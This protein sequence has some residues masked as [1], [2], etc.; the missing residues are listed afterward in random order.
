[1]IDKK[2]FAPPWMRANANMNEKEPVFATGCIFA[3]DLYSFPHTVL[4]KTKPLEQYPRHPLSLLSC[5]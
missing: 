2:A 5:G 3:E 1:M 4:I